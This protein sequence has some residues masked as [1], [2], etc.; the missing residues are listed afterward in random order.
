MLKVGLTGGIAVGKSFVTAQLKALGCEVADADVIAR[1]VV[2][3]GEPAYDD[4]VRE[5]GDGVLDANGAID[6]AKLGAIVFA[7]AERRARLNAIVHPRVLAAQEEW[8]DQV[9]QR[10]PRAIA[11]VDAALMIESGGY[12]RFD[13]LVVVHCEPEIQLARLME[14][15]RMTREEALKRINA[16]MPTAEKLKYADYALDTSQGFEETAR[17]VK[18]L[19]E[20]LR[21]DADGRKR[22]A[23]KHS[24]QA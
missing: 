13:K 16:Q 20:E 10:N 19:Y 22:E 11:V 3:P 15:N 8:L 5:F 24:P 1:R 9:A 23:E 6:R 21:R 12:K 17:R 4:I 14:R 2:E 7:D 18:L